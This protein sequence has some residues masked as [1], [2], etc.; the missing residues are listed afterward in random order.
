MKKKAKPRKYDVNGLKEEYIRSDFVNKVDELCRNIDCKSTGIRDCERLVN[1][2]EEAAAKT[3]P[4]IIKSTETK[5]WENDEELVQ[6]RNIRDK[7]DRYA[8]PAKFKATTKKI[9]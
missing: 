1:I 6:L 5:L 2:L 8:Q 7:T 9:R 3:L 4:S